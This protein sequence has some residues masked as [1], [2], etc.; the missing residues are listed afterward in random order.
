[1]IIHIGSLRGFKA[2][3]FSVDGE[4][5]RNIPEP[6]EEFRNGLFDRLLTVSNGSP[7][8]LAGKE[9]PPKRIGAIFI[10]N[11][12]RFTV[13]PFTLTHLIPV[14]AEH[15]SEDDAIS[16]RMGKRLFFGDFTRMRIFGGESFVR[17]FGA[18]AK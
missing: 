13:I 17:D 14:F 7:G 12:S 2:I 16:E 10:E 5:A 9:K 1:M 18:F 15:E 4:E 3:D 8:W 11:F 6:E